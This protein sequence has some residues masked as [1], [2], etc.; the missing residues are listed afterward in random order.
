MVFF[1]A[2]TNISYKWFYKVTP[3]ICTVVFTSTNNQKPR[4]HVGSRGH[5]DQ[6]LG[7]YTLNLCYLTSL[8][9]PL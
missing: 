8:L 3:L 1:R 4:K 7:Y 6:A 5:S 2:Q 9:R